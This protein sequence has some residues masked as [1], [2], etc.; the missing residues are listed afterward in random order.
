MPARVPFILALFLASLAVNPAASRDSAFTVRLSADETGRIAR[1]DDPRTLDEHLLAVP[2][3]SS[4]RAWHNLLSS[5]PHVAGSEGD[6]RTISR[7]L[8]SMDA[9]GLEIRRQEIEP[10]LARPIS[11]S[12]DIIAPERVTLDL[13]ERPVWSDPFTNHPDLAI[14]WNAYSASGSVTGE[15]VYVNYGTR[16]DFAQLKELGVDLTGKIAIARYGGNFRGYKAAYAEAAGAIGLII[17]SDP[18]DGGGD[19][20]RRLAY[21]EGGWLN[22]TSIQRGSIL[23]LPYP[24]DPLTPFTPAEP[25]ATRLDPNEVALPAIPVQPI[26][27]GAASEIM[28]RMTGR[29]APENW[30]GAMPLEYRVEGGPELRVRLAVEQERAIMPTAN[31]FGVI[32]GS[33]YPD[34]V[35]IIGC[36]HDAWSFGAGDPNAGSIVVLEVARAFASAAR[37]GHRPLR[38]LIFA[39]WGAEEFGIIG[40]TE[41]VEANADMLREQGVAYLNLDMAAMGLN[42]NASASP[43]LKHVLTEAARLVPQP[44]DATGRSVHEAW[45]ARGEAGRPPF[46]N[47]GGG[48]DHVAFLCHVGVPSAGLSAGGSPGVSYHTN[49]ETL[50]WYRQI[51]GDEYEPALM[52]TRLTALAAARLAND[53][54]LPLDPAM[55]GQ[56]FSLHFRA[57]NERA[58]E[59]MPAL[60]LAPLSQRIEALAARLSALGERLRDP[61]VE[62]RLE[63]AA[64][65]EL[66]RLLRALDRAWLH[67]AGL[68]G[69]PWWRNLYGASDPWSGYAAW[70]LP[71]LREA[72]ETRDEAMLHNAARAYGEVADRLTDILNKMD[73]LLSE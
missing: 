50:A 31:V 49:Y 15:I 14:G 26:G 71:L 22:E 5:E 16:A 37:R 67:D 61:L 40:S 6:A 57:L 45:T 64:I 29:L 51:V 9:M 27:W 36:H 70:M 56:D 54:V 4:L 41:W 8:L 17:F 39:H 52:L 69:R 44:G 12:L 32:R 1:G 13:R 11:A 42:F 60:D 58:S 55:M 53:E 18:A 43:M 59:T 68:P 24:G 19:G 46:G 25:G 33:T 38:T 63:R 62:E 48:S 20:F 47:L 3:A 23:T 65:V 28:M 7:L 34:E 72:I 30:A 73:A 21:P 10:L 35:I 2:T 66:N